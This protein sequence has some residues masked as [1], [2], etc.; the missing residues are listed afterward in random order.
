MPTWAIPWQVLCLA[1]FR[2]DTSS[3]NRGKRMQRDTSSG[4]GR[5]IQPAA[6]PKRTIHASDDSLLQKLL[7]P[8]V[9]MDCR[10]GR[11]A[12]P[13]RAAKSKRNL[14][15]IWWLT[16]LVDTYHWNYNSTIRWQWHR[17]NSGQRSWPH[18]SQTS[19]FAVVRGVHS[20]KGYTVNTL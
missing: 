6:T 7:A 15:S 1:E 10:I 16:L 5:Q 4:K 8:P 3:S 20:E 11:L 12:W 19:Q 17:W 18:L 9:G 2:E 13:H 14:R